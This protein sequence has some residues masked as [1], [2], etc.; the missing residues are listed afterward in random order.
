[1]RHLK[2]REKKKDWRSD[3]TGTTS[4]ARPINH[5]LLEEVTENLLALVCGYQALVAQCL[6]R[7]LLSLMVEWRASVRINEKT[8]GLPIAHVGRGYVCDQLSGGR[9]RLSGQ[10][11][12]SCVLATTT[13]WPRKCERVKRY[14]V[15]GDQ[16][17]RLV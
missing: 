1:M 4:S 5:T 10:P 17:E 6:Q 13:V 14:L 9:A 12:R 16:K 2:I 15:G 8:P 11:E 7:V 3:T